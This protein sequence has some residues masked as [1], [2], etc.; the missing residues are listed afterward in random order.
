MLLYNIFTS[1]FLLSSCLEFTA[2]GERMN[3]IAKYI[4]TFINF[5]LNVLLS[6]FFFDACLSPLFL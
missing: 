6:D 5:F 2:G 4:L 3:Y 1:L